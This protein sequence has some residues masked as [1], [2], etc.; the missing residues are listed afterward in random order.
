MKRSEFFKSVFGAL[1]VSAIPLQSFQAEVKNKRYTFDEV[2]HTPYNNDILLYFRPECDVYKSIKNSISKR[3]VEKN[4]F[5]SYLPE[6]RVLIP[7]KDHY[8]LA[9]FIPLIMFLECVYV[10]NNLYCETEQG[11]FLRLIKENKDRMHP[12]LFLAR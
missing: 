4:R 10:K 8:E 12:D 11:V 6:H 5:R 9:D 7:V 2:F 3:I 1:I